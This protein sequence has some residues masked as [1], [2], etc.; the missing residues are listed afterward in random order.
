MRA[1]AYGFVRGAR[2]DIRTAMDTETAEQQAGCVARRNLQSV[3]AA[4][5]R[6]AVAS[7]HCCASVCVC[8]GADKPGSEVPHYHA[9]QE[10][11]VLVKEGKL[12][13]FIGHQH[14]VQSAEAEQEVVVKPGD[15][16]M[17]H[18][19]SAPQTE[20]GVWGTAWSSPQREQSSAQGAAWHGVA[21]PIV[22]Q[23]SS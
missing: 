17:R 5:H 10:E 18:T 19:N 8:V 11:R 12:G 22:L 7:Q 15:A 4:P 16:V 2:C 1:Q 20:Q 9:F 21:A 13:Y 3:P 23:S 6:T 14:H